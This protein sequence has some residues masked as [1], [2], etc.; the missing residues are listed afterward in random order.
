MKKSLLFLSLIA[1]LSMNAQ[2][3]AQ[4]TGFTDQFRGLSEIRIVDA[5]TV[6]AVA[7]D[8]SGGGANVQEFTR[9]T[10][11]GSSWTPG[12]IDAGNPDLRITNISPVSGDTAWVGAFDENDGLGGVFK[13]SDAGVTWEQQNFAGYTTAGE[14]WFNCVHF[15]DGNVGLT[16]GDPENGEFEIYRTTDGG[17]TWTRI[18]AATLP[19]PLSGEYGYNGG[20]AA[21]G[22]SF[23]FTTNKGRLYRTTDRG[24]TWNAYQAPLTDFGSAAQSG[25][26]D[27]SSASNGYLL[28]TVGTTYTYYTTTNGAQTWSAAAPFTGT[29]RI[30]SYVPGTNVIVATS[31]AAPVGTSVSVDNGTTWTD[32]ESGDQRG[33]NAFLN[34][35]TGWSA[36]FSTDEVTGGIFKLT[37]QLGVSTANAAKFRVFPNPASSTVTV[38][39]PEVDAAKLSVTDLSGKVVMTRTLS[40]MENTVDISTLSTGA[41]FF[42]VSSDSKKEVI[43][44]L[45]N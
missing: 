29:R 30:L 37:G 44:I 8:G 14:S 31:Q 45:K 2:W 43:K 9:T 41:Y 6:W 35:T 36:G 23:W 34:M 32:V 4:A 42:E 10:D 25:S 12:L 13:T 16:M 1:S 33:A 24:V 5:N 19:N 18:A 7:Y 26:V 27:F 22:D 17:N 3:T 15:F 39:T 38:S 20:Y 11:G 21:N 40:G 28:K